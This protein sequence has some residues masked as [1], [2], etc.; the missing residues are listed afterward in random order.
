[1]EMSHAD[2]VTKFVVAMCPAIF[3]FVRFHNNLLELTEGKYVR[4]I[5]TFKAAF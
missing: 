3:C 4:F 1:M 5:L 2:H